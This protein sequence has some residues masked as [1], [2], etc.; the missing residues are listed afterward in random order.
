MTSPILNFSRVMTKGDEKVLR[1]AFKECGTM[2]FG[3]GDGRGR[4]RTYRSVDEAFRSPWFE[5]VAV[6]DAKLAIVFSSSTEGYPEDMEE[7]V[8]E[9]KSYAPNADIFYGG[10][11]EQMEDRMRTVVLLGF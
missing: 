9:T 6:K 11:K 10:Y 8:S 7:V 3:A 4:E 1:Q 2:R 5:D